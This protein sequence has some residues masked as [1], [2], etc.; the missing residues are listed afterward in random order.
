M[1]LQQVA[2][3]C[4]QG[5]TTKYYLCEAERGDFVVNLQVTTLHTIKTWQIPC[6]TIPIGQTES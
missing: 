2:W 6:D 1:S 4:M 3:L 5:F